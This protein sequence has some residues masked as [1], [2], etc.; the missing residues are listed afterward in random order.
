MENF[1]PLGKCECVLFFKY[2]WWLRMKQ[3]RLEALSNTNRYFFNQ[4]YG[5]DPID[6]EELIIYYVDYGGA[7]GYA[8]R[9]LQNN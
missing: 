2:S 1:C 8:E 7:K 4:H 3:Q 5:R 6:N 9:E